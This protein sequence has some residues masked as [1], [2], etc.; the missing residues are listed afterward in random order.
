MPVI[1]HTIKNLIDFIFIIGF[2][3]YFIS[4]KC[5]KLR[6]FDDLIQFKFYQLRNCLAQQKNESMKLQRGLKIDFLNADV[7]NAGKLSA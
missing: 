2:L 6:T 3:V 4:Q 5:S 1:Q 7:E